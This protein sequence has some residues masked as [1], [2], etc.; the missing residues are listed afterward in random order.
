MDAVMYTGGTFD[1]PHI[2]HVNFFRQCKDLFPHLQLLVAL[3]TDEFIEQFKGSK[4]LFNYTEREKLIY[5]VEYVDYVV[6]NEGGSDSKLTVLKY[7]PKVIVIG[8]DW[9]R[10]NYLQQM[11]FTPE[12]LEQ[13]GISLCY[14]PYTDII[15]TSE[16]KR[17]LSA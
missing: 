8:T 17:R 16:I 4:P 1:I 3:N 11:S 6:P 9:L 2:G 7:K 10:K 5:K 15:S 14:L 13:Q 12:W